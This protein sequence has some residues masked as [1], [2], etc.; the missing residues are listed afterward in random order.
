MDTETEAAMIIRNISRYEALRGSCRDADS[1][2]FVAGVIA[3][4]KVRLSKL[5]ERSPPLE[6]HQTFPD[7]RR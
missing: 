7:W 6:R 1:L 5:E 3:K 4:A 2:K